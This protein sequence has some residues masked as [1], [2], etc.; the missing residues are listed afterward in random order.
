MIAHVSGIPA[1]EL[2]PLAG[3]TG[4]LL[5]VRAWLRMRIRA[6]MKG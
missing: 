5:V 1:E 6:K 4:G 3:G 2:V